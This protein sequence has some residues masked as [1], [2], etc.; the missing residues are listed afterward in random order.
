MCRGDYE[1]HSFEVWTFFLFM[2]FFW[3]A[4]IVFF[5]FNTLSTQRK[6]FLN[7]NVCKLF[8]KQVIEASVENNTRVV[9]SY[10]HNGSKE[11]M[12][13]EV[14]FTLSTFSVYSRPAL[15]SI[16]QTE[17]SRKFLLSR[18]AWWYDLQNHLGCCMGAS[19]KGTLITESA[20]KSTNQI[21][22]CSWT[23]QQYL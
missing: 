17:Q 1:T 4:G 23:I 6:T 11:Y 22:H 10:S 2:L 19:L 5:Y 13:K 20:P 8:K 7:V 14:I 15:C 16:K 3:I 12:L 9:E 18:A 21:E